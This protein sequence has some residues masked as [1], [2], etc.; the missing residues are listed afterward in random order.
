MRAEPWSSVPTAAASTT[1]SA[2]SARSAARRSTP[3]TR[4]AARPPD[5]GPA[6]APRAED[7]ETAIAVA[8]D[9]HARHRRHRRHRVRRVHVAAARPVRRDRTSAR[10]NFGYCLLVPEGWEAGPARFGAEVTLTSSRRPPS[11]DGRRRSVDLESGTGLQECLDFVRA[12]RR[13][14]R[15]DAGP[16]Q[17]D[18]AR[19]DGGAPV[20]RH[21]GRRGRGD[22]PA[23]RGRDR[24]G[25]RGLADHAQRRAGRL[26]HRPPSC[27]ATC[28]SPGSS[29]RPRYHGR[30]A[31]RSSEPRGRSA[32]RWSASSRSATS[33]STS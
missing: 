2:A 12:A 19:R 15:P 31:S 23:A 18:L 9:H 11:R 16:P 25:R 1:R 21:G 10:T 5:R 7:A 3:A 26:R 28:S 32:G 29:A 14:G 27:S 8:T 33:R 24:R 6:P 20:G 13:G 17:R 4:A 22:L 30:C